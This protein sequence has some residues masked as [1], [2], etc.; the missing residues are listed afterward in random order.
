VVE[1]KILPLF[2]FQRMTSIAMARNWRL[3]SPEQ[4]RRS[5]SSSRRSGAQL[6]RFARA[7]AT[8]RSSTGRC[9]LQRR[10]RGTGEVLP[11][12]IRARAA[13]DRLRDARQ[14]GGLEGFDVTIAG[15]SWC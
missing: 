14:P 3:A 8:S 4:Q 2:D 1:S 15:V 11:E 10:H 7:I 5:S 6:F 9:N 13:V 12:A